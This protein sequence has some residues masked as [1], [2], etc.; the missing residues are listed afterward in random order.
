MNDLN[1][2]KLEDL[3]ILARQIQYIPPTYNEDSWTQ[4]D[5]YNAA[6]SETLHN[7]YQ[8]KA[9]EIVCDSFAPIKIFFKGTLRNYIRIMYSR[10]SNEIQEASV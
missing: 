4:D 9:S 8:I 3:I 2:L 1:K 7:K 6:I 10:N 5:I